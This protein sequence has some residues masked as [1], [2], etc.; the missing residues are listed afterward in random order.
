VNETSVGKVEDFA[1]A[2]DGRGYK[3]VMDNPKLP[4]Q[5]IPP[6]LLKET[7]EVLQFGASKY[8]P[9]NWM[10]GMSWTTVYGALMRHQMAWFMG[11]ELDP[12]SGL[13]HMAHA[14]CCLAFLSHFRNNPEYAQFDDRVF[15]AKP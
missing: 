13:P 5:L 4:L 8:A 15:K 7:A 3:T 9:N 11:E 6:A 10:R 14:A 1:G 12:E 2:V